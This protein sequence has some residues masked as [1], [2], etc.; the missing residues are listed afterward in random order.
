MTGN[1]LVLFKKFFEVLKLV[2][3][4]YGDLSLFKQSFLLENAPL[5]ANEKCGINS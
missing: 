1:L 4:I 5:E 2:H 3:T